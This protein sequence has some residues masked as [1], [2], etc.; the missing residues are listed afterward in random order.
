MDKLILFMT[1][2]WC[3][4]SYSSYHPGAIHPIQIFLVRNS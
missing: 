2:S 3:N 4:L 1:S